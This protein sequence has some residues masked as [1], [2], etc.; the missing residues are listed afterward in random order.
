M[1]SMQFDN[2][3]KYITYP[4]KAVFSRRFYFKVMSEMTG[5]GLTYV[6]LLCA[7]LAVPA[8]YQVKSA[9]ATLQSYELSTVVGMLPPSFITTQGQLIPMAENVE[10]P[11]IIRNSKGQAII[12][13]NLENEPIPDLNEQVPITLTSHAAI[14]NTRDGTVTLPW[15]SI[16]G[17]AGSQFEPLEMARALEQAFNSSYYTVWLMVTLWQFSLLA[18]IVLIAGGFTKLIGSLAIKTRVNYATALRLS[19]YGSTLP[20]F[21]MLMQFFFN[22]SFSYFVLCAVPLAYTLPFL[23]NLRK[24]LESCLS[25]PKYALSQQNPLYK[26]YEEQSRHRQDNSYDKGPDYQDLDAAGKHEREENLRA[27]FKRNAAQV[28]IR[29]SVYKDSSKSNTD[30][31]TYNSNG[32]FGDNNQQHGKNAQWPNQNTDSEQQHNDATNAKSND[33]QQNSSNAANEPS[34]DANADTTANTNTD[35]N[36]SSKQP[37]SEVKPNPYVLNGRDEDGDPL[38]DDHASQYPERG[39][40]KSGGSGKDSTFTP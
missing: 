39:E 26:F 10:Q 24:V 25:D 22:V 18:F 31:N 32:T 14:L 36:A 17:N 29:M 4:V 21:M 6:M 2:I 27:I 11:L 30:Y 34:R 1:Q 5:V 20:A 15:T 35:A 16:Y 19:A 13:Y 7:A 3:L 8:T 37:E 38:F 40:V 28:N 9:L 33:V 12:S 23:I